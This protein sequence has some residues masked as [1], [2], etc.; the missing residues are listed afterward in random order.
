MHETWLNQKHCDR[1]RAELIGRSTSWFNS[2]TICMNCLDYE[3]R[4]KQQM[5]ERGMNL[6]NYEGIGYVPTL[7]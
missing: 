7:D 2:D 6:D 4:L 3:F 5:T 1:C